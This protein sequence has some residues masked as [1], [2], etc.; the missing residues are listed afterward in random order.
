MGAIDSNDQI[1]NRMRH[2]SSCCEIYNRIVEIDNDFD[3]S[4]YKYFVIPNE[5]NDD[6]LLENCPF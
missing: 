4:Q 3:F 2:V 6:E 1:H 5:Q